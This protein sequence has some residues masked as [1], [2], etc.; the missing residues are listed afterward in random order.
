MAANINTPLDDSQWA[1]IIA[2]LPRTIRGRVRTKDADYRAF[3]DAVLWVVRNETCWK[4]V[5]GDGWRAIYVRFIRWV[6]QGLWSRVEYG[7]QSD[8]ALVDALRQRVAL[9]SSKKL[10]RRSRHSDSDPSE[11]SLACPWILDSLVS[12]IGGRAAS[13]TAFVSH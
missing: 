11:A 12:S 5:P 9:Y 1:T 8:P 2:H 7:I 6:D 10:R 4:T 3:V 13:T